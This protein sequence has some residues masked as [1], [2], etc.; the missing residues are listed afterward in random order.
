MLEKHLIAKT[1]PLANPANI[2]LW[3]DFRITVLA[4]RL[5]RVERDEGRIFCDEATEAVWFRDM[6]PVPF[7]KTEKDGV[8]YVKTAGATLVRC[9]DFEKSY[10]IL[11]GKK[12]LLDNEQNLR[13]TYCTLDCCD[14]CDL[15]DGTGKNPPKPIE[16]D[17]GVVS[18]N[19]V[20]VLDYTK[21]SLLKNDG[22]V[23][24]QR[25]DELDIYIFTYGHDYRA[26]VRAFYMLCGE[27]PKLPR[28]AL[29]NWWSR[30]YA[31][32]ERGYL[33]VLD[34]M[35]ERDIPITVA[36]VDMDWHW[37]TQNLQDKPGIEDKMPLDKRCGENSDYYGGA[38]GWTGYS[39]N[40]DLFPDYKA[41]LKKL[42][43]RGCA[44]T[45]NLHPATGVRWFED[46]YEEMAREMGIDPATERKVDLDFTDDRWINAYF[47][48]LHKPYERDGVDFWWMDWQQGTKSAI[49]DLDPLWLLNHYH[50]LDIMKDNK[51]PMLLSR[52]SEAGSQRFPVGFSGDT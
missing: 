9:K 24:K 46:M 19:G 11:D 8:L 25:R 41:F 28:Y 45:L 4:D 36:T 26:A 39:W 27:T 35:E 42:H 40:T 33:N 51:R 7:E 5:F 37:N 32:T 30:Y 44:V 16:L 10:V 18:K 17:M 1:R 13:G 2:V 6:P 14:G 3:G 29:G 21:S 31:Y 20:A 50:T 12:I 52:F 22:M 15:I 48:I 34:R 43:E 49:K 38:S 47:K 23:T